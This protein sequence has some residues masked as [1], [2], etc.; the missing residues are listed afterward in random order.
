MSDAAVSRWFD[1]HGTGLWMASGFSM[2][3][4]GTLLLVFAG[5]IGGLV[6]FGLIGIFVGPLVLAVGYR[7]LEAWVLEG[8]SGERP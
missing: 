8:R 3:L 1:S 7:L 2:A 4:G 6:A 5:V